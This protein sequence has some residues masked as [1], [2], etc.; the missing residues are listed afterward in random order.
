MIALPFNDHQCLQAISEA[1]AN[2]AN[3]RDPV[4][5]ALAEQFPTE[6][7]LVEH[8]RSLPQRDDLGDP[9]DGPRIDACSPPQRLQFTNPSPNCVERS[10]LFV[11]TRELSDPQSTYQLATVDTPV[12]L[13]TFPLVNGRP[14]VLDPRVTKDCVDCGLALA[15]PGPIAV[16]PRNAIAW[17][18]DMASAGAAEFRNGTGQSM[19]YLARNAIRRLV[20][21][22]A[23]PAE[24]EVDAIGILFALAE[25]VAR[26]YGTR[27]LAIVQTTARAIADLLEAVLERRNARFGIGGRTFETSEQVDQTATALGKVGLDLG[28][29]YLRYK[30]GVLGIAPEVIGLV[31]SR[32]NE[33]GRTLGSF[34]HPPDL[35][36]FSRFAAP[37]TA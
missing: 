23:V 31:E 17:T 30:L 37:R 1:A 14:V 9:S 24:A 29:L 3:A 28:S 34:A 13:H 2:M 6:P 11:S 35:A 16:E 20:D 22:G 18:T 26:R 19:V 32:M 25:R 33:E 8:F 7:A 5:V 4:V 21:R 36:T 27:A 15:T 10:A 12:G